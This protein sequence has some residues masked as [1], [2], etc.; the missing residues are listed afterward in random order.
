MGIPAPLA[1]RPSPGWGFGWVAAALIM[2]SWCALGQDALR[3]SLAGDAS[4]AMRRQQVENQ[5]Y[6]IKYG[7][8][9]LLAT[10]ELE[11]G[12]NDNINLQDKNAK[13]DLIIRPLL[14]LDLSYPIT[15]HN[16]L[17]FNIGVG[18][19]KYIWHDEFS[20][21]Y[22][23]S[24]SQLSFD[25]Y[26]KDFWI[27]LHDRFSYI[28]D[29]AR[30]GA[31]AST[32]NYG[33]FQNT[34]G[35]MT[36]WDLEDVTLALGYDHLTYLS[37]SSS[38]EYTDHS[39]EMLVARPGIRLNPALTTGIE[40]TASFTSYHQ[41]VLNDNTAYSAGVY[42][43]W[44][45]GKALKVDAR[46][47]YSIYDFDQTS[48]T[49]KAVNQDTWYADLTASHQITKTLNYAL[50]AGHE[51]RLGIQADTIE[52]WYVRP[53]VN[54]AIIKDLSLGVGAF[55][56]HGT[57][58]SAGLAGVGGEVYD[59]YGGDLSLSHPV[60]RNVM[61]ALNYRVTLRASNAA[62]RDYT[63]NLV[64]LLVTYKPQ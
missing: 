32:G 21:W 1:S 59:Y 35:E 3:Y 48:Q 46:F 29:S 34:A 9:R 10:P 56:E 33:S 63:Q 8:F 49:I 5:P 15:Q 7:D 64:G 28:Q 4:A 39:S 26:I 19:D 40:G 43:T 16:L 30:E 41:K 2:P 42:G 44:T 58:S 52:D 62:S 37:T 55:Y 13:D 54:W 23:S 14:G 18:Y 20:T 38:F 6:T 25:I 53:H 22:L 50:S 60:T 51:I 12:Y 45:P 31:V 11:V 27:N 57:Q 36:T 17:Q 47:G 24:G 61:L